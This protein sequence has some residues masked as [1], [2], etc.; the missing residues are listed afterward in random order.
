M[1]A[2]VEQLLD[3]Q[4]TRHLEHRLPHRG[5]VHPSGPER[6]GDVLEHRHMRIERIAFEGHGG[7]A[8]VGRYARHI[9]AAEDHPAGVDNLE[10]GDASRQRCLANARGADNDEELA[11]L[12][13]QAQPVEDRSIIAFADVLQLESRHL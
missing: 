1:G 7:V 13:G 3:A 5:L 2:A 11:F 6:A 8:P 4:Q 10:P 12:D 9:P